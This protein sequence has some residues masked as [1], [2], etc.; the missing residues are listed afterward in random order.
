MG[1]GVRVGTQKAGSSGFRVPGRTLKSGFQWVPGSRSEP[2]KWVPVGSGFRVGTQ[3][4]G[5]SGFRVPTKFFFVPTPDLAIE[6]KNDITVRKTISLVL[7]LSRIR[8]KLLGLDLILDMLLGLVLGLVVGI[9]L[10]LV[11]RL[12][13]VLDLS[14]RSSSWSCFRFITSSCPRTT[15]RYSKLLGIVL[16]VVSGLV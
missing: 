10:G 14:L 6:M 9:V 13:S 5:S 2:R 7:S 15:S 1:S 4:V 8:D 11:L 3:K 16:A 12:V